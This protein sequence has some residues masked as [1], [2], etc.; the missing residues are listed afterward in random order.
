M[1]GLCGALDFA[2]CFVKEAGS[3]EKVNGLKAGLCDGL[4]FIHDPL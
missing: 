1:S 4:G 3:S 2:G